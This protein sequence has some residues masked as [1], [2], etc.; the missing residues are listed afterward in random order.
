MAGF[1]NGKK[2]EKGCEQ[3]AEQYLVMPLL[4][5]TEFADCMGHLSE[6]RVLALD[7]RD[8]PSPTEP[9]S[10]QPCMR[11]KSITA[12]LAVAQAPLISC[13]F[14]ISSVQ[15]LKAHTV[16]SIYEPEDTLYRHI[17]P[18]GLASA[19]AAEAERIN[20]SL[21]VDV[22]D[23][24]QNEMLQPLAAAARKTPQL[25]TTFAAILGHP[26]HSHSA[27]LPAAIPRFK[28]HIAI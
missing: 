14:Y 5:E 28:Q 12:A 17:H 20:H 15:W 13:S 16:C 24:G 7:Q 4:S 6:H 21:D 8:L 3:G 19:I 2:D 23:G 26:R 27:T 11:L 25:E 9:S 18:L 10:R 1:D 22:G